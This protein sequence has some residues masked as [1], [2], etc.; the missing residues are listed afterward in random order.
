MKR[1]MKIFDGRRHAVVL[2][3]AVFMMTATACDFMRVLAGRPTGKDIE[4]KRVEIMKA[5]EA[6]LQARLDSIRQAEQK[7]AA[8]SVAAV[9]YLTSCGVVMSGPERFGGLASPG[10]PA[11]YYVIAG[12]FKDRGNARK[13]AD[14]AAS[15]GY[16]ASLIDCR[17]GMVAVGLCPS[18][19]IAQIGSVYEALK[20]ET[21]C[22]PDAWVLVIE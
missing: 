19:N 14:A 16:D 21:F 15:K 9:E 12:A 3:L 20:G 22:P 2:A 11:R 8:D 6:A 1:N 18:D 5:E 13:L 17:R 10:L 4:N 7:M